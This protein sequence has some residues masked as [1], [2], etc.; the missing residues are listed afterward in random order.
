ME[1]KEIKKIVII[2]L[3]LAQSNR[4]VTVPLINKGITGGEFVAGVGRLYDELSIGCVEL[5]LRI[6]C[7]ETFKCQ[8]SHISSWIY[9]CEAQKRGQK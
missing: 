5:E 9:E 1:A 2:S 6:G 7:V 3:F 8:K 4:W